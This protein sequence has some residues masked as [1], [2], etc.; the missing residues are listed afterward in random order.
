MPTIICANCEDRVP[1][2]DELE[3]CFASPE[4][5][6]RVRELQEQSAIVLDS[7]SKERA[8]VGEVIST[9]ALA[10]QICREFNV[11]DHGIDM[12]IEFKDDAG[13]A[14]GRKLYLQLKSGDSYLR[15]RKSDG[16]EIFTIKDERHARYWMEQAFHVMLV[17][18]TSEGEVRWMEVRDWLKRASDNGRK[19][20]RQIVFKG[21]RF[22]VM[23]VRCWRDEA[24]RQD[25]P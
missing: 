20:V 12:E 2:W 22:D 6:Q 17:I 8:L 13:E 19:P 3:Q 1:L 25:L 11:S 21:D 4:M 7:E 15:E 10:G 24:L 5:Q 9:V 23:G 16:A 18:R 14:T